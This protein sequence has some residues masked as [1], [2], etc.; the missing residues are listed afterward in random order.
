MYST[1]TVFYLGGVAE[2]G[3]S[4]RKR[5]T[6]TSRQENQNEILFNY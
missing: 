1:F 6:R 3:I 2:A 4:V 5:T